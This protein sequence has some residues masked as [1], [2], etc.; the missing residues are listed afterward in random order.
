MI[1]PSTNPASG[2]ALADELEAWPA[3]GR[4]DGLDAAVVSRLMKQ[5]AAAL[6]TSTPAVGIRE[7]LVQWLESEAA[8]Y[9]DSDAIVYSPRNVANI[10]ATQAARIRSAASSLPLMTQPVRE[11]M[12][13]A[14]DS[15]TVAA[16]AKVFDPRHQRAD[17][18]YGEQIVEILTAALRGVEAPGGDLERVFTDACDEAGCPYDNEA[19]LEAISDLKAR[20]AL[21]AGTTAGVD[22]ARLVWLQGRIVDTVYLDDGKIIDVSGNDLRQAIDAAKAKWPSS[23]EDDSGDEKLARLQ[24]SCREGRGVTH[25]CKRAGG[26]VDS[27]CM[28]NCDCHVTQRIEPTTRPPSTPGREEIARTI[29]ECRLLDDDEDIAPSW[30][31][32]CAKVSDTKYAVDNPEWHNE[33]C[34]QLTLTLKIADAILALL[35]NGTGEAGGVRSEDVDLRVLEAFINHGKER[36]EGLARQAGRDGQLATQSNYES[37]ANILDRAIKI[38]RA[39]NVSAT[40]G[41]PT[42]Y[43]KLPLGVICKC[44]KMRRESDGSHWC[45]LPAKPALAPSTET[46]A[47]TK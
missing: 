31:D 3:T 15:P 28:A 32:L 45:C 27:N 39:L 12:E 46:R 25:G 18:S 33:L 40:S 5:A 35:S 34:T 42:G 2:I 14:V 19:L 36:F 17:K 41:R 7:T 11:A 43:S 6:R 30:G 24:S 26:F 8:Q 16:L 10:L 13:N 29:F 23:L 1:S 37:D 21:A 22:S 47:G 9:G 38:A 20:A 4:G 44:P